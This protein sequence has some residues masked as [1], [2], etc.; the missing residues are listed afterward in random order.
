MA[1]PGRKNFDQH[2][3]VFLETGTVI[4]SCHPDGG[5]L[6]PMVYLVF[7]GF[8]RGG[9]SKGGVTGEP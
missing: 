2:P 6:C 1:I 3:N 4:D 9:V 8:L 7:V 5:F